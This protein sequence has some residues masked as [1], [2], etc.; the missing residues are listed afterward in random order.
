MIL[1]LTFFK[2]SSLEKLKYFVAAGRIEGLFRIV[3]KE[4]YYHEL[5]C[6]FCFTGSGVGDKDKFSCNFPADG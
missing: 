3:N 4:G 5:Q 6:R 2:S 1:L